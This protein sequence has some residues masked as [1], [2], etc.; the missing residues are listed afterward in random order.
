V[1][2]SYTAAPRPH[3]TQRPSCRTPLRSHTTTNSPPLAEAC[4]TLVLSHTSCLRAFSNATVMVL[5]KI[6]LPLGKPFS[7]LARTHN[8]LDILKIV[9]KTR[10]WQCPKLAK[11]CSSFPAS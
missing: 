7:H 5:M 3:P 1:A 2:H 4:P 6:I 9:R 8:R 10:L 11:S